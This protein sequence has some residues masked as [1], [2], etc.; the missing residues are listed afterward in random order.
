[1]KYYTGIPVL[2]FYKAIRVKI[3]QWDRVAGSLKPRSAVE[4]K[5]RIT[6]NPVCIL[7]NIFFTYRHKN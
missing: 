6:G 2:F 4:E 1:M 3:T 5:Y 7:I